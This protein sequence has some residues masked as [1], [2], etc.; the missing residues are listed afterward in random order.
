MA[1]SARA[2]G[3]ALGLFPELGRSG[4]VYNNWWSRAC[5]EI[6]NALE[7]PI[8]TTSAPPLLQ[9]VPSPQPERPLLAVQSL[10]SGEELTIFPLYADG[11]NAGA[12]E[13]PKR[14]GR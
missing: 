4:P 12:H 11:V 8:R 14:P 13:R 7:S 3:R 6:Q 9:Y 5:N 2:L 1:A 10:E